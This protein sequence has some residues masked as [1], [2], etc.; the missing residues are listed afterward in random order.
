MNR[1]LICVTMAPCL[2]R[3]DN[4][5]KVDNAIIRDYLFFRGPTLVTSIS[6]TPNLWAGESEWNFTRH[7]N[8]KADAVKLQNLVTITTFFG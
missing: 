5:L 1:M 3:G 8:R 2:R 4:P 6:G 7:S